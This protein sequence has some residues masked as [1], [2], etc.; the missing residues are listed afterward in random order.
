RSPDLSSSEASSWCRC[1]RNPRCSREPTWKNRVEPAQP[2]A[3][4][5]PQHVSSLLQEPHRPVGV[6][7]KHAR[8]GKSLRG[9]LE[10]RGPDTYYTYHTSFNS[11]RPEKSENASPSLGPRQTDAARIRPRPPPGR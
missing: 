3:R 7:V 4:K 5:R 10:D 1:H 8:F 11:C 6:E 2:P 9:R